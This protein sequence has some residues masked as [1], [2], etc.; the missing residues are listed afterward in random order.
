MITRRGLIGGGVIQLASLTGSARANPVMMPRPGIARF[1]VL[2]NH[3]LIGQHLA[4]SRQDGAMLQV[5]V[6]VELAVGLGPLVLYRYTHSVR[7]IWRDGRFLS[8]ESET[9]DDGMRYRVRAERQ[10]G[11]VAVDAGNAKRAVLPE[12]SILLTHWNGQCMTAP[13]FNPQTGD[14][15]APIVQPR[16][17]E[18]VLRADG[19]SVRANRFSLT[20]D[21]VL[22]DWY[23]GARAWAAL[24]SIARDGSIIVY[25]RAG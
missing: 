21:V 22:D 19:R 15:A 4:T 3:G 9:N 13:L 20:G 14:R 5:N 6:C 18:T 12:E 8:L 23:D 17:E 2:R 16:G 1:D 10:A 11:G 25:R 24:R 7:E